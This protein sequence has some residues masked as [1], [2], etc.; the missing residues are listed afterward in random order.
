MEMSRCAIPSLPYLLSPC[1]R[2][3]GWVMFRTANVKGV[4]G[5]FGSPGSLMMGN[6][7]L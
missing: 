3:Y 6:W 4:Y 1:P 2:K 7:K 5:P